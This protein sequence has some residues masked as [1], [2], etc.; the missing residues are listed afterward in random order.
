LAL[1]SQN[2]LEPAHR[3]VRWRTGLSGGAPDS[4]WCPG[5]STVNWLLSGIGRVTWLK[6]TGLSGESSAPAP[7]Y[8]GDELVSLGKQKKIAAKNHR[9][10]RWCTGLFGG[11]PDCLVSQSRPSQRSAVKSAGDTWPEPTV[12]WAHRTVRCAPDSVRCANGTVDSTVG[13]ARKGKKS[14]TELLQ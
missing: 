13:C 14:R 9:I 3:T 1:Y 4:V 11:A 6:F 2:Q 10:V 5:C 7:K 12:G 8:I